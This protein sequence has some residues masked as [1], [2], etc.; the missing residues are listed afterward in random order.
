MLSALLVHPKQPQRWLKHLHGAVVL[1]QLC[2]RLPRP[3]GRLR[4]R[5][6]L[7]DIDARHARQAA[8][9]VSG[10]CQTH[11]VLTVMAPLERAQLVDVDARH[12]RE[13]AA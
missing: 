7:V 8:A 12:A 6:Q 9:Q 3:A 13:A 10:F 1:L 4:Q 11:E 2:F 5:A